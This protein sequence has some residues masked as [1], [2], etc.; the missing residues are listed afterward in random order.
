MTALQRRFDHNFQRV[1]YVIEHH[2]VG[3]VVQIKHVSRDPSPP[4][5]EYVKGGG[6]IF[7]DMAIHNLDMARF[8][9]GSEPVGIFA[10]GSCQIDELIS[11]LPGADAFDTFRIRRGSTHRRASLATP[12]CRTTSS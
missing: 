7:K 11:A 12:T 8:L 2:E 10:M 9:V 1:K 4:Q 6:G 3:E 5:F